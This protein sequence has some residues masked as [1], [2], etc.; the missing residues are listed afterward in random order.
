M[1]LFLLH[2]NPYQIVACLHNY[3]YGLLLRLT[4]SI[5]DWVLKD[6][7]FALASSYKCDTLVRQSPVLTT[8]AVTDTYT[9]HSHMS[10]QSA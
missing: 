6:S 4:P 2:F 9:K 7:H 8:S 10:L 5:L 3:K 1:I